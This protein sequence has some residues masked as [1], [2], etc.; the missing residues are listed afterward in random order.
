L[1]GL[2]VHQAQED[3]MVQEGLPVKAMFLAPQVVE[4]SVASKEYQALKVQWDPLVDATIAMMVNV[5]G[6]KMR[7][8]ES[9]LRK[10]I[11]KRKQNM[12]RNKR[13]QN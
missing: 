12:R 5:M 6:V 1:K 3:K 9:Y 13:F 4:V 8:L 7:L 2:K 11:I 10:S